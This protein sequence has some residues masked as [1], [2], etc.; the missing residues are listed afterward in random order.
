MGCPAIKIGTLFRKIKY[1]RDVMYRPQKQDL[2]III[3]GA[4]SS[5]KSMIGLLL[6][7]YLYGYDKE[8]D[9]P[10]EWVKEHVKYR[11]RRLRKSLRDMLVKKQR[12]KT[13]MF[14]EG[15][16]QMFSRG[17]MTVSN[18]RLAKMYQAVRFL[19]ATHIIC[20]PRLR[21]LDV[22]LREERIRLLINVWMEFDEKNPSIAHR[23][24]AFWTRDKISAFLDMKP[25]GECFTKFR[26]GEKAMNDLFADFQ[27][28]LPNIPALIEKKAPGVLKAYDEA[29]DEYN[30][31]LLSDEFEDEER[32]EEDF[33]DDDFFLD[34]VPGLPPV[35]DVKKELSVP[36][37]T[38]ANHPAFPKAVVTLR[39]WCREGKVPGAWHKTGKGYMVPKSSLP[40][41]FEMANVLYDESEFKGEDA[42]AVS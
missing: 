6:S 28:F 32:V 26:D 33:S 16:T 18:V 24:A 19:M 11:A 9:D 35:E 22:Y 20:I 1:W 40:R 37:T 15:G 42:E 3:T 29:K 38:I 21:Y 13:L 5:G 2:V 10:E 39:R 14:D 41:V 30:L 4:E 8:K 36:I 17:S 12:G 34:G 7:L 27:V 23:R 31:E 25:R